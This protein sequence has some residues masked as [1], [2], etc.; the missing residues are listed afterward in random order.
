MDAPMP[1]PKPTHGTCWGC[2]NAD[3]DDLFDVQAGRGLIARL[4]Q[5]CTEQL[6]DALRPRPG[7]FAYFAVERDGSS[8]RWPDGFTWED[9]E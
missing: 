2:G 5:V 3:P 9:Y 7:R 4:C 6:C 1:L 8:G